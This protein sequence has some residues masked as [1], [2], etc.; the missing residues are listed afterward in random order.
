MRLRT[1]VSAKQML[2]LGLSLVLGVYAPEP[3]HFALV[4]HAQASETGSLSPSE[5][6]RRAAACEGARQHAIEIAPDLLALA[7]WPLDKVAPVECSADYVLPGPLAA[8][9]AVGEAVDDAALVPEVVFPYPYPPVDLAGMAPASSDLPAAEGRAPAP[10][11]ERL[12]ALG[13]ESLD[14]IRGGF[15]LAE[16]NLKFSFGIERAVFINGQ[17]V[18]TTVLNLRDLQWAAGKGLA[19][20]VLS[21]G[22]AGALGVIQN[23]GGNAVPLQGTADMAGT[24]IQNTLNNQN[25]QTVTTINAVVNSAQVLRSMSVQSAINSGIVNSLR[26]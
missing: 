2:R 18:A 10:F 24:V 4:T 14:D 17:L 19:P 25:I 23:G 1:S 5:A 20:E 7:D 22:G 16:P 11:P 13:D 6:Q 8:E 12:A 15:E 9:D 26:H 21:S 3:L